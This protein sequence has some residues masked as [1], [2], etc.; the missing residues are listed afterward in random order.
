MDAKITVATNTTYT[1]EVDLGR[2]YDLLDIHIPAITSST[3]K[4]MVAEKEGGTYYDLGSSVTTGTTTGSYA[5]VW[6]IMG[7]QF[8]KIVAGT[9]QGAN[10]T[11]RVRG[12]AL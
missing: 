6:K 5:D 8:I 10:R 9:A 7:Y 4:I 11:F 12:M 3:L 2:P 1:P